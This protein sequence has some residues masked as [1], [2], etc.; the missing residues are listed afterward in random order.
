MIMA[1][2]EDKQQDGSQDQ[3][4]Q[5]PLCG[6]DMTLRGRDALLRFLGLVLV[7]VAVTLLLIW[8]PALSVGKAVS[9][10]VIAVG[11]CVLMRNPRNWWCPDC[12]HSLTPGR[13]DGADVSNDEPDDG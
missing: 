12:W 3:A 2:Q 9:A 7:Y 4:Q 6:S 10:G 8:L 5:C 11:G 13:E 1:Q